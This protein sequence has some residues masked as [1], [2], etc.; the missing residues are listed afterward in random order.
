M[1]SPLYNLVSEYRRLSAIPKNI[2]PLNSGDCL[3]YITYAAVYISFVIAFYCVYKK[4]VYLLGVILL[5]LTNVVYSVLVTKDLLESPK[6]NTHQIITMII[7][8]IIV[9]NIVS[10]TIVVS[11]IH[12]LHLNYSKND[13][14]IQVAK[15]TRIMLSVYIAMFIA[16]IVI[17]FV[18]SAFY[19]VEPPDVAFFDYNFNGRT[20]TPFFLIIAFIVKIISSMAALAL[21]GYMV[22]ASTVFSNI[23][24][25]TID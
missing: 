22:V 15:K 1:S 6:K 13:E 9:L 18:L 21:S 8:S 24:T 4:Q 3:R 25:K 11:T 19:F 23:K 5:Y 7:F 17:L 12:S 2:K 20:V 14:Q 10:S 16:T